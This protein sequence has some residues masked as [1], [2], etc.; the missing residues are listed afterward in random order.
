MSSAAIDT[1]WNAVEQK[2]KDYQVE[3][4]NAVHLSPACSF[5]AEELAPLLGL[6][7]RQLL[8]LTRTGQGPECYRFSR[9]TIRF[10]GWQVLTWLELIKDIP[11]VR[12]MPERKHRSQTD[13]A[14][15]HE[16][17]YVPDEDPD[18]STQLR[19]ITFAEVE[20]GLTG[21]DWSRIEELFR[22][23]HEG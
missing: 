3:R 15:Y 18:P 11:K 8:Y 2:L 10:M 21:T 6:S 5:S 9:K 22:L 14:I 12:P 20:L 19:L 13:S 7:A 4:G 16:L 1:A 17:A 23:L